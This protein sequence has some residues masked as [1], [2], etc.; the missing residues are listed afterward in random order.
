M[1]MYFIKKKKNIRRECY[2]S[3]EMCIFVLCRIL[4]SANGNQKHLE[5]Q[6]F[7]KILMKQTHSNIIV[8]YLLWFGI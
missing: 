1:I 5:S 4:L 8:I 3:H 6:Y 7:L 2:C